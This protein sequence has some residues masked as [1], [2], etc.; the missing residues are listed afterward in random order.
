MCATGVAAEQ[1][2]VASKCL[3]P[4]VATPSPQEPAG[5]ATEAAAED[6][7]AA[8][9]AAAAAEA[10]EDAAT[11][12]A[13]AALTPLERREKRVRRAKR[14]V[15]SELSVS[16]GDWGRRGYAASPFLLCVASLDDTLPRVDCRMVSRAQFEAQFE[17]RRVPC[18]LQHAVASWPAVDRAHPRHWSWSNLRARFGDHKFKVGSDD[19][20]S[21]VR[22][23]LSHFIDYTFDDASGAG[24]DDSPLY[25][26][27]GTFAEKPGSAALAE[28]YAVP[29]YFSG[30]GSDL[31]ALA[32]ARRRPPHR[33]VVFGP[34][35]S[36]SSCHVDPLATAA[37]NALVSGRKR[38]A[39]LPPGTPRAHA[40]PRL[41]SGDGGEAAGWFSGALPAML[42]DPSWPHDRPMQGV[43]H[44]GEVM[45]V[46][47]GALPI[48]RGPMETCV[49]FGK[50]P[51][52][53][54]YLPPPLHFAQGGGTRC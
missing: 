2:G 3:E 22:L 36:G 24:A 43:Q 46:P 15:R 18:I 54:L 16:G 37:W 38:W 45:F 6:A 49:Y 33:W 44:A 7:A 8:A 29:E 48:T 42:S 51:S 28:D 26:F 39:L 12:A 20:G 21:A 34:R 17:A 11:A 13:D 19:D 5:A 47:P 1:P 32:G 23:A 30:P 50:F 9:A 4:S 41:A 10:A 31:F 52:H 53:M 35:R 40:K 27:D 14:A 25:V